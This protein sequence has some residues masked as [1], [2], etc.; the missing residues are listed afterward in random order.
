MKDP[1][2]RSLAYCN[3]ATG[4]DSY[5]K[6]TV[7]GAKIC[8]GMARYQPVPASCTIL[9]ATMRLLPSTEFSQRANA[10]KR[11]P[12]TLGGLFLLTTCSSS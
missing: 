5:Y 7:P 1:M 10:K 11:E 2:E 12:G 3:G 8:S 6:D 9:M 4:D